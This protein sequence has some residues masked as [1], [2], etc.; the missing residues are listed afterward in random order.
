MSK[1]LARAKA[2]RFSAENS[3]NNITVD[4]AY[5]D[6]C[7]FNLQQTIEFCLKYLVE[8]AGEV[9]P[10]NHDIR[11]Q[12]NRLKKLNQYIPCEDKLRLLASLINSWEVETRYSD[13]FTALLEDIDD[14]RVIADEIIKYCDSLVISEEI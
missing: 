1:L 10:E 12:I 7:C 6:E 8:M 11:S 13:S 5:I 2:K 14:V 4:D 9:Y 3:Y